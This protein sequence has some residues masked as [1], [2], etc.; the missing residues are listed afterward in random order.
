MASTIAAVDTQRIGNYPPEIA[1]T[2]KSVRDAAVVDIEAL[3]ASIG[4]QDF[5]NSVVCATTANL[6]ATRSGNVLTATGNGALGAIDGYTVVASDR[7]LVKN[8]STG[9]DN[10]IYTATNLG[11]GSTPW[12]LT[13]ATD[14]DS[15]AEVT[16]EMIVYVERGSV[17]ADTQWILDV[18]SAITLNT[19]T[20]TFVQHRGLA[21]TAPADVTK[22]AAAVGTSLTLAR[23]D[24][25]HDISTAVAGTIAIG[26]AAAEGSATSL[27]RS[28][29][30][31]AVPAPAAPA[32]VTKAAASAGAAT[33]F[34]RA[35]HKHDITTAA[36][37]TVAYANA[38]GSATS[39]ARSD[40]VHALPAQAGAI[41]S[42]RGVV[43]SN[44][45]DLN[46][47]AVATHDG[48]TFVEGDRILLAHQTTGAQ[49]GIYTVGA[50]SGGN[51]PLTRASDWAAAA[52]LA[53]GTEV[54]V[55]E[56]TTFAGTV[57][58]ATVAGAITVATTS[59]A[60]YP[61]EYWGTSAALSGTPGTAAISNL[62]ILHATRSTV[63]LTRRAPAGTTGDLSFGTLTA[64]QGDGSFT[65]TSTGNETSTVDYV[66]KNRA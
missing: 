51:A 42:V 25:K 56:G 22:A 23:S 19:T 4:A 47:F 14:A 43:Q 24:H 2:L 7:I 30:V 17:N 31:H 46:S 5:K 36:A 53:A 18:D 54:L 33:T 20:L 39:L 62:W 55:N 6:N 32:N 3:Q 61:R 11:S 40:H 13:R 21:T 57:W 48:L 41:R 49:D 63:I 16:P 45:A 66:I 52:V 65:I 34:A 28:D 60:F 64:G 59:P 8:Q 29:H 15:S 37:T 38:E 27:A 10:G 1:A 35:D 50:V 12:V 44:V 26:D 58:V 9:A